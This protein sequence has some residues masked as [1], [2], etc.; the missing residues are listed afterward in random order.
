MSQEDPFANEVMEGPVK[1]DHVVLYDKSGNSSPFGA[2]ST[3]MFSEKEIKP[4]WIS[5]VLDSYSRKKDL[6]PLEM[7]PESIYCLF[8]KIESG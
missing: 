8:G 7:L 5:S 4:R 2:Y 1:Y 6:C 3:T